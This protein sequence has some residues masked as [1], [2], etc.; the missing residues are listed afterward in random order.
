M[1]SQQR[2]QLRR[3]SVQSVAV[4]LP[5]AQVGQNPLITA[6]YLV[7]GAIIAL[8]MVYLLD[9]TGSILTKLTALPQHLETNSYAINHLNKGDRL[10]AVRF[11]DRW[12]GIETTGE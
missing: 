6:A 5:P 4:A 7:A 2:Y 10:A 12:S 11:N 9:M 3:R 8:W 1:R